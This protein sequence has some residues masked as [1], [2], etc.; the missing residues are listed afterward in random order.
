LVA[1]I[2]HVRAV[3]RLGSILS[4]AGLDAILIGPYDLSASMGLTAQFEHPTFVEALRR[5]REVASEYAVPSGVHIVAPDPDLL[6]KRIAEG[7][8]FIAF[9]I[10]SVFLNT[11]AA[12]PDV[13]T[14]G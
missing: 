2:E 8:R 5:V 4:V 12:R 3:N 1:M 10:D 7:Y 9:S 6:L 11:A 14:L 13:S